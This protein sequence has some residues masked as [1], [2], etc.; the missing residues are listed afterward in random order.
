ML[1]PLRCVGMSYVTAI[2][3]W[4]GSPASTITYRRCD[5]QY[6]GTIDT[7][8][9]GRNQLKNHEHAASTSTSVGGSA[10]ISYDRHWWPGTVG[11]DPPVLIPR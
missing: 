1:G 5:K 2:A 8:Q 6:Q 11:S 3:A 9:R 4:R 10:E 7:T